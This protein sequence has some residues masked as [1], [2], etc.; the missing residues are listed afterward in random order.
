MSLMIPNYIIGLPSWL[1]GKDSVYQLRRCGFYP[2]VRKIPWRRKCQ[3]TP[4]FWPGKS[5]EQKSLVGYS[6]WGCKGVR[7]DLVSDLTKSTLATTTI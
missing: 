7:R 2:W 5:N 6:P 1:S 3:P 4:V